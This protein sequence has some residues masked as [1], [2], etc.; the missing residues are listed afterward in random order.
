MAEERETK[1]MV[2]LFAPDR[3]TIEAQGATNPVILLEAIEKLYMEGSRH[4]FTGEIIPETEAFSMIYK[5]EKTPGG[6]I[7]YV[8]ERMKEDD[9]KD[10]KKDDHSPAYWE[11]L[12]EGLWNY[13]VWKDGVQYVGAMGKTLAQAYDSAGVPEEFRK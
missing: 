4:P 1:I 13:A 6:L 9:E 10:A 2:P 8:R 7:C 12:V 11:G 3:R 5:R